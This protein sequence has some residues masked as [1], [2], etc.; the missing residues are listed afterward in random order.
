[1]DSPTTHSM[2]HERARA[3]CLFC[4]LRGDTRDVNKTKNVHELWLWD[5]CDCVCARARRTENDKSLCQVAGPYDDC[6]ED[7]DDDFF[8]CTWSVKN[9]DLKPNQSTV[10]WRR[11]HT[12]HMRGAHTKVSHR[13]WLRAV[14]SHHTL[15][16]SSRFDAPVYL[17]HRYHRSLHIVSSLNYIHVLHVCTSYSVRFFSL[18]F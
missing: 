7:D 1:M 9:Y 2:N 8:F 18:H 5:E 12:C 11:T 14:N 13:F 17:L 3:R 16:V 4:S 6:V 15:I 10:A